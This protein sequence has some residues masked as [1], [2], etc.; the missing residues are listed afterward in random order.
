[1]SSNETTGALPRRTVRRLRPEIAAALAARRREAELA[2]LYEKPVQELEREDLAQM[3]A[4]F[5]RG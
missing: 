3:R 1:V 4:A 5:F 2:A